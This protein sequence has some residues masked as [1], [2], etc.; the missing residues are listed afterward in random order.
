MEVDEWN[1]WSSWINSHSPKEEMDSWYDTGMI[2]NIPEL[3]ALVNTPQDPLWHP[4]GDV[5]FQQFVFY[6]GVF[7]LICALISLF[8]K[9]LPVWCRYILLLGAFDLIFLALL[10]L[11]DLRLVI[12]V[13]L[14]PPFFP[15][16]INP[17]L[18]GGF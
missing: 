2:K 9:K 16:A 6:Q 18:N 1:F 7:Y 12:G 17:L 10:N 8:I 4:E 3:Y 11:V 5:W 13:E 15:N 14:F